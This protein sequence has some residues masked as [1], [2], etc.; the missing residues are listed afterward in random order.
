MKTSRGAIAAYLLVIV[1][2]ATT[3]LTGLIVFVSSSQRKSL[4]DVSRQQALGMAESGVYYYRWYLA[5]TLD[6]K[7][8][9]EILDFLAKFRTDW[10]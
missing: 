2:V 5:H 7:N 8:A 3:L 1:G 4:N 10:H 9:Q 6:G